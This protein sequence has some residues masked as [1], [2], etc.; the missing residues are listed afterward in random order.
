M[1]NFTVY[2][3]YESLIRGSFQPFYLKW[4]W[5]KWRGFLTFPAPICHKDCGKISVCNHWRMRIQ[6]S[7]G[8]RKLK[9]EWLSADVLKI[10]VTFYLLCSSRKKEG[11]T[12]TS[13][14]KSEHV[15]TFHGVSI[16]ICREFQREMYNKF[17]LFFKDVALLNDLQ[18]RMT[19]NMFPV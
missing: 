14:M 17:Q 12:C 13:S 8:Q 11:H 1:T 19:L 16:L 7:W 18:R 4:R 9:G 6:I 15:T 5:R 3:C 10:F 2:W